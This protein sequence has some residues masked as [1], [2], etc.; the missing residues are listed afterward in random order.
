MQRA[1]TKEVTRNEPIEKGSRQDDEE[2]TVSGYTVGR[3]LI[4]RVKGIQQGA[5]DQIL[6]P[7]HASWPNQKASAQ[8]SKA[9]ACELGSN[10]QQRL[11]PVVGSEV[12]LQLG[13]DDGVD[14]IGRP[15]GYV[16]HDVN[17]DMFL[18]VPRAR[19]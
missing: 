1:R 6:R 12:V 13:D 15:D 10:D 7:D 16:G 18:D 5:Y 17:E 11:E 2:I 3:F 8:T 9:K 4:F 14:G 19:I